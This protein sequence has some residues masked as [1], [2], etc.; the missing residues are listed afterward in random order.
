MRG[1]HLVKDLVI[2]HKPEGV[3]GLSESLALLNHMKT[4][5]TVTK[6]RL[7]RDPLTR[8]NTGIGFISYMRYDDAQEALRNREQSVKGLIEPFDT[9]LISPYRPHPK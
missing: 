8:E 7:V 4:F 9:I 1:A 6:F 5:G 3:H 2:K